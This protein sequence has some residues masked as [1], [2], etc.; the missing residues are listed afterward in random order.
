MRSFKI[1]GSIDVGSTFK[2]PFSEMTETRS[3]FNILIWGKSS[4]GTRL[5]SSDATTLPSFKFNVF[6]LSKATI[7]IILLLSN[8]FSRSMFKDVGLSLTVV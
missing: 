2:L 1:S 5:T 7:S 6:G 3:K 4:V 8:G